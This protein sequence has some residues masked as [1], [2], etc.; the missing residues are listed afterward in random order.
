MDQ[1]HM[2]S[3]TI[4]ADNRD[5]R[6]LTASCDRCGTLGTIARATRHS[7]PPLVL[8]YCATCWPLAQSELEESRDEEQRQWRLAGDND[9]PPTGWSTASRSWHDVVR[10]LHLIEQSAKGGSAPSNEDLASVASEIR[11][12]ADE[13][14]GVMPSEVEAFLNRYPPPAA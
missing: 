10:F 14:S 13:M 2:S 3:V 12:T 1:S 8:R 11:A 4:S 7:Q 6:D 9:T 5:P